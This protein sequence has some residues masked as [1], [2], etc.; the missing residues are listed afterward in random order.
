[1]I[2]ILSDETIDAFKSKKSTSDEMFKN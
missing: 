1:M 2:N